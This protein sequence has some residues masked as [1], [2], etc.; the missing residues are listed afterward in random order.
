[1]KKQKVENYYKTRKFYLSI[2]LHDLIS[3]VRVYEMWFKRI[4]VELRMFAILFRLIN[5]V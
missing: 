5:I 1:M 4:N 2:F 3:F